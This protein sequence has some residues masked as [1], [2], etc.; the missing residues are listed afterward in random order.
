[1]VLY[2]L[3]RPIRLMLRMGALTPQAAS[4]FESN[5][6]TAIKELRIDLAAPAYISQWGRCSSIGP[7]TLLN[8][9][10]LERVH[11]HGKFVSLYAF[12]SNALPR[13][14]IRNEQVKWLRLSDSVV[15]S[16]FLTWC[17]TVFP[18]LEVFD[19]HAGQSVGHDVGVS[20]LTFMNTL[21][22]FT[23]RLRA[24][25]LDLVMGFDHPKP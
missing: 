3:P 17:L 16:S 15:S 1:M 7:L 8:S 11:L 20:C 21:T 25:T 4:C 19:C 24:L 18:K 6:K 13:T 14:D 10:G 5:Q 2:A 9:D 23:E 12:D 22:P